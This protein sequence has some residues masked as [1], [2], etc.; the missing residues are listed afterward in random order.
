MLASH[1]GAA[2]TLRLIAIRCIP[3]LLPISWVVRIQGG[4]KPRRGQS[5]QQHLGLG[6][7]ALGSPCS[8]KA[9]AQRISTLPRPMGL[10]ALPT[11]SMIGL[12]R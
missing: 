6:R 8:T 2:T 7:S 9:G 4:L 12:T 3:P 10:G 5:V 11:V 1:Q